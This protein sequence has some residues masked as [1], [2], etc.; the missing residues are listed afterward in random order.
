[1]RTVLECSWAMA[2]SLTM[3]RMGTARMANALLLLY[4]CMYG[5]LEGSSVLRSLQLISAEQKIVSRGAAH[6]HCSPHFIVPLSM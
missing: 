2:K 5:V 3:A 4:T 6:H 1:M